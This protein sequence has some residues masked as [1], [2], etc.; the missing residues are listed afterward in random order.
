LADAEALIVRQN[1]DIE[2]RVKT[3]LKNK[4]P[5]KQKASVMSYS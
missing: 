3:L 2:K 1:V 5:S 4:I